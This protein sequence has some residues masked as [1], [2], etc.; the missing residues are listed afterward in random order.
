MQ[1]QLQP[2]TQKE[3]PNP[4]L[5]RLFQ[6]CTFRQTIGPEKDRCEKRSSG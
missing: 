6:I 4:I 1:S 3:T 5:K 2:T